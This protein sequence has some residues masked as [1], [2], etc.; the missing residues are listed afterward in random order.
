[1]TE[2]VK[3][4]IRAAEYLVFVHTTQGIT[5]EQYELAVIEMNAAIEKIKK[6]TDG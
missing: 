4:L 6:A 5:D 1:M 3:E 2:E